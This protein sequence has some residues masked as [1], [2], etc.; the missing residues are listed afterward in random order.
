MLNENHSFCSTV[1][2]VGHSNHNWDYFH[3]LLLRHG[4]SHVVDV[5]SIPASGRFKH[6]CKK[7]L[8][9]SCR[10]DGANHCICLC[11]AATTTRA[12]CGVTR[13]QLLMLL[14]QPCGDGLSVD[15]QNPWRTQWARPHQPVW[16]GADSSSTVKSARDLWFDTTNMHPRFWQLSTISTIGQL[17]TRLRADKQPPTCPTKGTGC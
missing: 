1:Y 5:R 6:F 9:A 3:A 16:T 12:L 17:T 13:N 10:W 8:S 2:T 14:E 15:G 11:S 7:Q 4:I